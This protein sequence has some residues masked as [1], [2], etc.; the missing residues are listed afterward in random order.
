MSCSSWNHCMLATSTIRLHTADNGQWFKRSGGSPFG[1]DSMIE[2]VDIGGMVCGG[3]DLAREV[4]SLVQCLLADKVFDVTAE[5]R[6][7]GHMFDGERRFA[8]DGERGIEGFVC[9][10]YGGCDFFSSHM[11]FPFRLGWCAMRT[12]SHDRFFDLRSHKFIGVG[13]MRN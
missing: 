11:S 4:L 12:I 3:G 8:G 7:F 13:R 6:R 9:V 10:R 2:R 1:R 5:D